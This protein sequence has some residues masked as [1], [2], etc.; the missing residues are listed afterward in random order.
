MFERQKN[1]NP[2]DQPSVQFANKAEDIKTES[3]AQSKFESTKKSEHID[4]PAH[5]ERKRCCVIQ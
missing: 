5:A 4:Q 2:P 3:T 1:S